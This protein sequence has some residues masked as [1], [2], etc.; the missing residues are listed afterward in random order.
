MGEHKN[1][2]NSFGYGF[3]LS[4][5]VYLVSTFLLFWFS[6]IRRAYVLNIPVKFD[7]DVSYAV[8]FIPIMIAIPW[9]PIAVITGLISRKKGNKIGL[10]FLYIFSTLITIGLLVLFWNLPYN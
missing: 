4:A 5:L 7:S 3:G 2:T 9:L 8:I 10:R 1:T 6:V